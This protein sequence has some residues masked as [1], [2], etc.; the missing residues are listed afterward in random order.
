MQGLKVYVHSTYI[1]HTYCSMHCTA[2]Q[3]AV[4]ISAEGDGIEHQSVQSPA[5]EQCTQ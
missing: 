4:D 1:V 2:V 3:V 5:A